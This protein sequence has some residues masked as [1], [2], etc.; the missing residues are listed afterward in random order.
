MQSFRVGDHLRVDHSLQNTTVKERLLVT[1][2][3]AFLSVFTGV[4]L[5]LTGQLS[6]A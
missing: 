6:K 3:W 2:W 4:V 5:P 1:D